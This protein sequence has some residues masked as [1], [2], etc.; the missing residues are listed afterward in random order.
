[1]SRKFF[2]C[3][4]G[5]P[6]CH[7]ARAFV[8]TSHTR[9]LLFNTGSKRGSDSR[10]WIVCEVPVQPWYRTYYHHQLGSAST[11]WVLVYSVRYTVSCHSCYLT[12]FLFYPLTVIGDFKA[13]G[14]KSACDLV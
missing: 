5:L 1:M 4:L 2:Y 14:K 13:T 8:F 6:V 10:E 3:E 9:I 12:C 11:A 7:V